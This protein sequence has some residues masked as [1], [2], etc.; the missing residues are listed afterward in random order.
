MKIKDAGAQACKDDKWDGTNYTGTCVDIPDDA[1]AIPSSTGTL[2]GKFEEL[3]DGSWKGSGTCIYT[4]DSGDQLYE[5]WEEGSHLKEYT[6]TYT[7][8]TGKYAKASGGGTYTY[9][10]HPQLQGGRYK[11]TLDL[12]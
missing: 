8:G 6:Y 2:Q 10:E 3:S 7:G 12:T 9:N 1:A 11:G 5:S 4:F